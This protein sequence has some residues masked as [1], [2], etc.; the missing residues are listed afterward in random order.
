MKLFD[1][2]VHQRRFI[3]LAVALLSAAGIGSALTCSRRPSIP[4]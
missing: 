3:Y 1:V 2:L 4:S